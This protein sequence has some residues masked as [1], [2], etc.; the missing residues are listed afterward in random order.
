MGIVFHGMNILQVVYQSGINIWIVKSYVL[1]YRFLCEHNFSFLWNQYLRIIAG[2][3][4]SWI[5]ITN[6]LSF[7]AFSPTFGFVTIFYFS[8]S[9]F[10]HSDRCVV[11]IVILTCIF[12]MAKDFEHI[13]MSWFAISVSSSVIYLFMSLA[14]FLTIF[15]LFCSW[16]MR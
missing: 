8:Y 12:L 5:P 3:Y 15:L 7:F 13:S 10:S 9:D 1:L 2:L 4:S 14:R 16:V 6:V 11:I